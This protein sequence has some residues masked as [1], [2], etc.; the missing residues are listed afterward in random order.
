M[1]RLELEAEGVVV[2]LGQLEAI[3]C[4]SRR[5]WIIPL[6]SIER[7]EVQAGYLRPVSTN[8]VKELKLCGST[9]PYW[10]TGGTFSNLDESSRVFY[11]YYF[12]DR[13]RTVV[14][15]LRDESVKRVIVTLDAKNIEIVNQIREGSSQLAGLGAHINR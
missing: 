8:E 12:S 15:T 11:C 7:I 6:Q 4:L 14:L 10:F 9:I 1:V 3:V 13:E 2:Q 5:K